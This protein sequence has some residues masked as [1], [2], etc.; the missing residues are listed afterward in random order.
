VVSK[1]MKKL[2]C[3]DIGLDCG[4]II[5]GE[6]EED[7]INDAKQH[8]WEVHAIKQEEMTSEM[9]AKITQNIRDSEL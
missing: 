1:E 3:R 4:Y 9:K 5:E 2:A 7:I 8:V 6:R